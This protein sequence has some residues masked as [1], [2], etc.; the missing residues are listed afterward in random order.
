[1]N[2]KIY[3]NTIETLKKNISD[4]AIK[5]EDIIQYAKKFDP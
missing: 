1:M 4:R 5:S 2:E 3:E